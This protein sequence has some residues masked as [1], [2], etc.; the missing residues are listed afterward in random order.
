MTGPSAPEPRFSLS[1]QTLIGFVGGVGCG[2]FFGELCGWLQVAGDVFVGL[3]QMTVLPYIVI[4]LISSVG[5]LAP[6]Q[7]GRLGGRIVL[8]LLLFWV[9]GLLSVVVAA[10]VYPP[11]AAPAFYSNTLLTTPESLNFMELFVPTNP[12]RSLANN[13]IPAVVIFSVALGV[14]VMAMPAGSSSWTDLMTGWTCSSV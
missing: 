9:V 7:A 5:R 14:A 12:F 1:L 4:S 6:H 3:L 13:W 10:A 8:I 2:L 11:R